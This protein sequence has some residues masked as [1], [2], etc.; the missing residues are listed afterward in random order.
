MQTKTNE[1]KTEALEDLTE[2]TATNGLGDVAAVS[3]V[4][5]SMGISA[6]APGDTDQPQEELNKETTQS[7]VNSVSNLVRSDLKIA[8]NDT[9]TKAASGIAGR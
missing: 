6:E 3:D 5:T 2:D 7:I 4:L 1:E 9:E 8:D